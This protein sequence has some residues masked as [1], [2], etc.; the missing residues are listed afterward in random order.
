[1][2]KKRF[3]YVK[4]II[5]WIIHFLLYRI[6]NRFVQGIAGKKNTILVFVGHVNAT[7]KKSVKIH[8][9]LRA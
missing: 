4:K 3:W 5:F 6:S 9:R 2:T 7:N 1:M 8:G